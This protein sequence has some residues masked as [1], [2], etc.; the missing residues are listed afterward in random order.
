MSRSQNQTGRRQAAQ[1]TPRRA[2]ASTAAPAAAGRHAHYLHLASEQM[3]I[4]DH[5][6][7]DNYRQHAE[8]YFRAAQMEGC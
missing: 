6:Q 4:G 5:V 7:A 3:R 8:H 2:K 1:H